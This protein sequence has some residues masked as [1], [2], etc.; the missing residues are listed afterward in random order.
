MSQVIMV[1]RAEVSWPIRIFDQTVMIGR[2]RKCSGSSLHIAGMWFTN[3]ILGGLKRQRGLAFSF[4]GLL[5]IPS[6]LQLVSKTPGEH[7]GT[8]QIR[9]WW[10]SEQSLAK[11]QQSTEQKAGGSRNVKGLPAAPQG[12]PWIHG[13]YECCDG[14]STCAF[15][16]L[17]FS[18]YC[19]SS[20]P[21]TST[22]PIRILR[23]PN[24]VVAVFSQPNVTITYCL[25]FGQ[26][27]SSAWI[28]LSPYLLSIHDGLLGIRSLINP[29][30]L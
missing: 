14:R 18:M 3:D 19:R 24:V 10:L 15:S 25:G 26:I 4:E 8:W 16:L 12:R 20:M 22:I 1:G 13:L 28:A 6:S 9:P 7:L 23:T 27:L 5:T 30:P 17:T 2:N 29:Q 21:F 11:A